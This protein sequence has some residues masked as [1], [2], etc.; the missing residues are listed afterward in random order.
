M[1]LSVRLQTVAAS[2]CGSSHVAEVLERAVPP[3]LEHLG[4]RAG[5]KRSS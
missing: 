2:L 4:L 1:P 3:A 5:I